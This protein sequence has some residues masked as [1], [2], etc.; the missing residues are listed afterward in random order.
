[1]NS[2]LK[3]L[4]IIIVLT[5]IFL[6]MALLYVF[7]FQNLH[8]ESTILTARIDTLVKDITRLE[9]KQKRLSNEQTTEYDSTSVLWARKKSM[10]VELLIQTTADQL[11]KKHNIQ[12]NLIGSY[13]IENTEVFQKI[14]AEIEAETSLSNAVNFLNALEHHKPQFGISNLSIRPRNPTITD[15]GTTPVRM[16]LIIWGYAEK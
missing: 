5:P 1:M 2:F 15:D 3:I 8:K 6:V 9:L 10:P 4:R 14:S 16:R 12:P 7:L 11:A 13:G